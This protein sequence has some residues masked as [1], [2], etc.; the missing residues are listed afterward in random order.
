VDEGAPANIYALAQSPDGYLWI[1]SSGGLYRF[2]GVHFEQMPALRTGPGD[3]VSVSALMVARNGDLWIGYQSGRMAIMRRGRLVDVSHPGSKRWVNSFLEDRAGQ[4]WA[5]TGTPGFNILRRSQGR[6][7]NIDNAWGLA[8]PRTPLLREDGDG[9][10]WLSDATGLLILPRGERRFRDS[11]IPV[12][13][14]AQGFSYFLSADAAGR[15]WVSRDVEGTRRLP[16]VLTGRREPSAAPAIAPSG[17]LGAREFAFMRDGSI[18]GVTFSAGIFHIAN[19]HELYSG[20]TPIEEVFT[21][22]DG[23]SSDGS[24][25]ML[26][27]REGN[28]WIGTSAGLDRF[29]PANIRTETGIPPHSRYGYV[30]MQARD[31]SV[32]A[33]DSDTA[34]R[35]APGRAAERLVSDLANPQALC[36]AQDGS[37]WLATFDAMYQGRGGR[38]RRVPVPHRLGWILDCVAASDGSLW[39]TLGQGGA[40]R[41]REGVWTQELGAGGPMPPVAASMID[42]PEGLLSFERGRGL[43]RIDAAGRHLIAPVSVTGEISTMFPAHQMVLIAGQ[44]SLSRYAGG[45]IRRMP[46]DYPWL[47]G[48][49]GIVESDGRTW[50]LSLAGI[51]SVRTSD[52]NRGFD[53]PGY[54]LQPEVYTFADG[55]PAPSTTNYARNSAVRGGDGRLWFVTADA[56]ARIDPSRLFR[57]AVPP[58]VRITRLSSG[59]TQIIDPVSARLPAGTSR[60]E[61]SYTALSLSVPERVRFRYR[62]EGVDHGWVDP[63]SLRQASYTNLAPGTYRFQVIAANND[64]VWNRE[65][66]TLEF[67]IPP[68]FLQSIWFKLLLALGVGILAVLA[69]RVR[70]RRVTAGLQ[71]RFDARIAERE[72]IA[73]ELHDTLLQ[74]FHGLLLRF[75]AVTNRLP[76]RGAVREELEDALEKAETVLVDGRARVRDLRGPSAERDLPDALRDTGTAIGQQILIQVEGVPRPLHPLVREEALA[77]GQEAIRNAAQH[78]RAEHVLV[79]FRYGARDF[80]LT[81]EDDGQGLPDDVRTGGKREGH[82]GLVGMRERASRIN[83]RLVLEAAPGGGTRVTLTMSAR[84]AYPN[85]SWRWFGQK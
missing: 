27:D 33:V 19:P 85:R 52:L 72:R 32:Y 43:Y 60:V 15:M 51:V 71:S 68:T 18:W 24:L 49:S 21:K 36:E 40:L 17:T 57:N 9:T 66:T 28:I 70:L 12:P 25:S 11:G 78:A 63:R 77:I 69:Y 3:E 23:L 5:R 48:I 29:R 84:A 56:L 2:D 74:G 37:I 44:S 65:G 46:G 64:G 61:I 4:I 41:Y 42:T 6:W 14:G 13:S 39:F 58:P 22:R 30:L 1:G 45:R 20:N 50:L 8:E 31:G 79:S 80:A 53:D 35:I 34:Y 67:T 26:E 62:L 73:R 7:T 59:G 76:A 82:F 54:L 38:F 55:L 16:R 47:R 75:Q 81:V 83:G 10:M